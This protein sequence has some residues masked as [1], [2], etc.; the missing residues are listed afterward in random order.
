MKTIFIE[1]TN[2]F[3]WGK[4]MVGQFEAEEWNRY[5]EIGEGFTPLL[6]RCGW[7]P[8]HLLVMDLATGEGAIFWPTGS[9][10]ADLDKHRV[11]VCPLFEPFLT[12]LYTQD[13]ADIQKLPSAVELPDAPSAMHGYRRA[14]K[15]AKN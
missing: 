6:A 11:W 10:K 12:W 4:F 9:A 1:A 14:G 7:T 15:L 2:G 8:S 13:L 3:N 5:S